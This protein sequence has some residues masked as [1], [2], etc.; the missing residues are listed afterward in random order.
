MVYWSIIQLN[1]E[2]CNIY[3]V[4]IETPTSSMTTIG[5][6]FIIKT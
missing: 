3:Y 2:H 1:Q 5:E 6:G 4:Q